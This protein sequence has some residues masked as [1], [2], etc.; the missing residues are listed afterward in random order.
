MAL[1]IAAASAA[2]DGGDG[3][4]DGDGDVNKPRPWKRES[5]KGT[6]TGA[7]L[8]SAGP[9]TKACVKIYTTAKRMYEMRLGWTA[10]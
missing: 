7:A 4:G 10:A 6:S 5:A 8:A 2:D 3:V 1:V 9:T